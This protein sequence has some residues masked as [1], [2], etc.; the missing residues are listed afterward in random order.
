[1]SI[2]GKYWRAIARRRKRERD[3][4]YMYHLLHIYSNLS[5]EDIANSIGVAMVVVALTT[6]TMRAI[7]SVE[8]VFFW[9]CQRRGPFIGFSPLMISSSKRIKEPANIPQVN[10][11]RD[12]F[13]FRIWR[14]Y[15]YSPIHGV[16]TASIKKLFS[17]YVRKINIEKISKSVWVNRTSSRYLS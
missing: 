3:K 2:K 8:N 17:W 10:A 5:R 7:A 15:I 13:C 16:L 1:M 4:I 9:R 12:R 6:I 14:C 11:T